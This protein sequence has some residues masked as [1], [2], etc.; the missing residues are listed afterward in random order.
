[1]VQAPAEE[2]DLSLVD[3][4]LALGVVLALGIPMEQV[5]PRIATLRV[6]SHR[7]EEA[8]SPSGVVVLDD[9]YNANPLGAR[10]ALARLESSGSPGGRKVLVTPGMVELGPRQRQENADLGKEAVR[11]CTDLVVVGRTN[12]RWIIGGAEQELKSLSAERIGSVNIL[13]VDR[14]DQAVAWVREN[15]G[16][17]DVV[18]Y[19]NDLPDHFP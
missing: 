3:L 1:V 8:V 15:L 10:R 9:T 6:P 2:V 11:V 14:R 19:L 7:L 4:S 16:S 17:G 5:L 18:L 13:A 12:R